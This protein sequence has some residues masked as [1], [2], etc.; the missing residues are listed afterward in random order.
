MGRGSQRWDEGTQRGSE[1]DPAGRPTLLS[2]LAGVGCSLQLQQKRAQPRV[3]TWTNQSGLCP[4]AD[5]GEEWEHLG[6]TLGLLPPTWAL[7]QGW[8][9]SGHILPCPHKVSLLGV[10]WSRRRALVPGTLP[11]LAEAWASLYGM[12]ESAG[13]EEEENSSLL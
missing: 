6:D 9:L 11:A 1:R 2:S 7:V 13:V 12:G 8:D 4:W 3:G 5:G 10:G